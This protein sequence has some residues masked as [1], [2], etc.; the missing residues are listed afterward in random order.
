M[1][2]FIL[3]PDLFW[4]FHECLSWF[5]TSILVLFVIVIKLEVITG[6]NELLQWNIRV[7][8]PTIEDCA[9]AMCCA[10]ILRG[11]KALYLTTI[12]ETFVTGAWTRILCSP[13]GSKFKLL[14]VIC[15]KF[16]SEKHFLF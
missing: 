4:I 6:L 7:E 1:A 16:I 13:I 10:Q 5:C 11:H 3:L 9:E 15:L 12:L 14:E 2:F 8:T